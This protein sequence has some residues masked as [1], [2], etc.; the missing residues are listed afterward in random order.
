VFTP[1][2][3]NKKPQIFRIKAFDLKSSGEQD[4]TADLRVMNWHNLAQWD[5]KSQRVKKTHANATRLNN[6]LLTE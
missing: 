2:L 5:E 6:F 4:R 1:E 3:K